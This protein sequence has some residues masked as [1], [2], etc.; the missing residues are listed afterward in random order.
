M[1]LKKRQGSS[2]EMEIN[3]TPMIDAVFLLLIFFMVTTVMKNPAQL[4]MMLPEAKNYAKLES[5][6]LNLEVDA[7]GNLALDGQ[8]LSID[9]FDAYL[10]GQKAKTG[11]NSLLIKADIAAKHGLILKIMQIA[12]SVGI[13]TIAMAIDNKAEKK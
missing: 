8:K 11:N 13:E 1:A 12:K 9:S 2:S 5:R 4:K 6:Q 7:Q 10:V 3:M